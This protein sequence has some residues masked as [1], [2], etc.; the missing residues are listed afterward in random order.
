MRVTSNDLET[1]VDR[2]LFVSA[3]GH[4]IMPEELWPQYLEREFHEYLPRLVEE[5]RRFT[6]AMVP[7]NDYDTIYRGIVP[8]SHYD[9]FDTEGLHRGGQWAGAWDLDVRLAQM[10]HEGVAAEFVFFG[11]FRATDL[12]YNVSNTVYPTEVV[13][14]G[15]RAFDRWLY[16]AFG[17]ASDRLLL[18][19]AVGRSLERD[20]VIRETTW[21]AE[22]GFTGMYMPGYTAHPGFVPLY[23]KYWDPFW[24]LCEEAGIALIV[25]GGYGFEPGKSF[26]S[27]TGTFERVR[28]AG[29]SDYVAV[30][31]LRS[32]M[33]NDTFFADLR[34]RRALW[35]LMLGG[36][37]DRHPNLKVMMTEVRADWVP[38][39]LARLDVVY[40]AERESLPAKR[41]PSDYWPTNCMAGLSFMHRCEV[42]MRHDIGLETLSFGRDYPHTE[43]TWPNTELYLR[44]LFAGVPLAE[45]RLILGENL[46]RFLG[47]D[48]PRLQEVVDRIGFEAG[49]VVGPHPPMEGEL[50]AH[51]DARCGLSKP[52]E[53]GARL[54]QIQPMLDE[55]VKCV[56]AH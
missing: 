44:E 54:S 6:G 24:A 8:G 53:R 3:D 48:R 41:R 30:V 21:I 4:A 28:A 25:H 26:G 14:A 22:H 10:D 56:G 23:D 27:L 18:C 19:G 42:E 32:G 16:D 9:V 20:E 45:V 31:E 7:L 49:D 33:F 35:Q 55:D 11:Y 29:G 5:N 37:F 13:D 17:S 43:S 40:E 50:R 2:L 46:A 15:V 39:V 52:A 38:D 47:F 36:V 34:N 1:T 12:F 51:I